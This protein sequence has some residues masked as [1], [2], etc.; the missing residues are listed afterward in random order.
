MASNIY[1]LVFFTTF[2]MSLATVPS[3]KI[4]EEFGEIHE[5]AQGSNSLDITHKAGELFTVKIRG[6]PTTG[7]SWF[8]ENVRKL[9]TSA[10]K[11]LN[12]NE[13]GSSQKYI[14]DEHPEGMVGVG[15]YYYFIFKALKS[16]VNLTL[17]FIY[18][19]SCE[20]CNINRTATVNVNLI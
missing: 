15:G 16:N 12:V 13:D 18:K 3:S 9:D 11:P 1:F 8:L 17:N 5:F 10:I 20:L 4:K 7:F 14:T 19:R 2:L 6:N